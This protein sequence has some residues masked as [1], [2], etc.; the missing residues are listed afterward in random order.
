MRPPLIPIICFF[1]ACSGTPLLNAQDAIPSS[2]TKSTSY[3]LVSKGWPRSFTTNGIDCT[4]YQPQAVSWTNGILTFRQAVSILPQGA[5]QPIF[6]TVKLCALTKVDQEQQTVTLTSLAVSKSRFPSAPDQAIKYASQIIGM[7]TQWGQ[8]ISLGAITASLAVTEAQNATAHG[9]AVKNSPPTIYLCQSPALLV[10]VDGAP[11]LRNTPGSS[12][13]RVINTPALLAMDQ[14][15]GLYYLRVNGGWMQAAGLSGPWSP[16]AAASSALPALSALLQQTQGSGSVQLYDPPASSPT[17]PTTPAI[18]VSTTPAELIMTQG[19]PAFDPISGTQLL[20]ASNTSSSLFMDIATQNYFLLISGRWFTASSLSGPWNYTS[21][22]QLPS[23]FS[24]IP[25]NATAGNVLASVAGTPQA[26]EAS[27]SAAIPQTASISRSTT[28]NVV[29]AGV[30][31]FTKIANTSLS[32]AANTSTPVVKVANSQYYAVINGIW[33]SSSSPTGP[34]SV[35]DTVPPVIYTIPPSCPIYYATGV[36]V[37]NASHDTVTVGYIPAY[38]G[39]CITPEGVVVYGTG[40]AYSPYIN[41]DVWIAPPLTYGFG[42]GFSCG[43]ATGFVFGL[44]VDHAWGCS[45]AWGPWRGGWGSPNSVNWNNVTVNRQNIYN[46][47][48]S[49]VVRNG[50]YPQSQINNAW[51]TAQND[52]NQAKSNYQANHPAS[53]DSN[54]TPNRTNFKNDASHLGDNNLFAGK[55]GQPYRS[56]PN[57]KWQQIDNSGW[58]DAGISGVN[59]STLSDLNNQRYARNLGDYRSSARGF[60]GGGRGGGGFRR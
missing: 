23:D 36:Y 29:Y 25:E 51:S 5:A 8:Q 38:F 43:L 49:N 46:Q 4:I 41:G 18:F 26:Q 3:G 37:Y 7:A 19:P 21:A 40:Y 30:P 31:E 45:P 60:E 56:D 44:S 32:Y 55:D 48:G 50:G 35:A 54:Q 6:G 10:L 17:S 1:L 9:V 27:I 57:G 15:S 52:Y 53:G 2:D 59:P 42:A 28:T 22:N 20:H 34:W 33:F 14:S 47:W 12:L 11:A 13:L 24:K 58:K 16:V 39:T